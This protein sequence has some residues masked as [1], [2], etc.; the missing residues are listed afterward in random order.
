MGDQIVYNIYNRKD[1]SFFLLK[2]K[3]NEPTNKQTRNVKKNNYSMLP[4]YFH[5]YI[6]K[7]FKIKVEHSEYARIHIM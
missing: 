4:D 1:N 2:K 6:Y 7:S 3:K 5:L